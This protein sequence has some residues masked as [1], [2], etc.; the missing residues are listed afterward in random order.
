MGELFTTGWCWSFSTGVTG[1][2][3][4]GSC[5]YAYIVRG[6]EDLQAW[7]KILERK[8]VS[9][10]SRGDHVFGFGC[11]FFCAADLFFSSKIS[12]S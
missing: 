2:C 10:P 3:R 9:L 6:V 7:K 4:D 1:D 12:F 8:E 11:T 5:A